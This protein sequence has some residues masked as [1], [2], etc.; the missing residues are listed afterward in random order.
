MK[1]RIKFA[2]NRNTELGNEY[3]CVSITNSTEFR[4]GDTYSISQVNELCA[5]KGWEVTIVTHR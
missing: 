4:P 2:L 3:L 1:T 5:A